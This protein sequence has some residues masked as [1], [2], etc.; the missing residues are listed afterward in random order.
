MISRALD[1]SDPTTARA[2]HE[3]VRAAYRV[4]ADLIGSDA[5]PAL[6]ETLADMLASPLRWL[7]VGDPPE[8]VLAW[9]FADGAVDIDRLCV[10]PDRF[11]RG[12]ASALLTDLLAATSG[13]VTV[14]T[15]AANAPAIA[16]YTRHGFTRAG[17]I[18]PEPGLVVTR[19]R[20][21]RG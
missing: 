16:L 6:H 10:R 9:T 14:A 4:E 18:E 13:P 21:E 2:A 15:G 20:L 19:F 3:V 12:L 8:A 17:D 11:R 1:L 5:I 7:G